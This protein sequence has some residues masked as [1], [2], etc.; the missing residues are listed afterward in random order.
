[1]LKNLRF[2]ERFERARLSAAPYVAQDQS[3]LQPLGN[4]TSAPLFSS[5][6]LTKC[7]PERSVA[8]SEATRNA[9]SKSLP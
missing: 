7:H 2:D 4:A 8:E 1:V 3:R 6:L 5:V 9:Q